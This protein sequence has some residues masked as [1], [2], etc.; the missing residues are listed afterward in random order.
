MTKSRCGHF[1]LSGFLHLN[2]SFWVKWHTRSRALPAWVL[3]TAKGA[4]PFLCDTY[5]LVVIRNNIIHIWDLQRSTPFLLLLRVTCIRHQQQPVSNQMW[6]S[7]NLLSHLLKA[8]DSSLRCAWYQVHNQDG[9]I[10]LQVAC[11]CGCQLHLHWSFLH[12]VSAHHLDC[13]CQV[14]GSPECARGHNKPSTLSRNG[15]LQTVLNVIRGTLVTEAT[16]I[17]GFT[18]CSVLENN[19]Q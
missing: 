14:H 18:S 13:M 16:R 1:M 12:S 4:R 15:H 17:L 6:R 10:L 8:E 3:K 9:R 11:P 5:L 7:T 19:C 2:S